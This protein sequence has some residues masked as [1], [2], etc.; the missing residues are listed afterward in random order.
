MV[1]RPK[2]AA[3]ARQFPQRLHHATPAWV[4]SGATYHVRLRASAAQPVSLTEPVLAR[5]LLAS[6]RHYHDAG[7]WHCTLLLLM[8]DH[9]HALLAFAENRAMSR[10]IAEWKRFTAWQFGIRWQDN[11]FDHRIRDRRSLRQAYDY[12]LG[13]P[14]AKGLVA[15]DSGWPWMWGA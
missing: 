9:L 10:T 5:P 3:G 14:L 4:E 8:P 12:I 6:A 1:Y 13:N 2:L 7:R 11:F 15:T